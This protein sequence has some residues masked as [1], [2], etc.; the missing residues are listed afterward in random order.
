VID[1]HAL[2][3]PPDVDQA[4]ADWGANC[5]PC[6]LAAYMGVPVADVRDLFCD[7]ETR[8]YCNPTQMIAAI[9][10]AGM[11]ARTTAPRGMRAGRVLPD[12]GMAFLQFSGGWWDEKPIGVQYRKTHWIACH[13]LAGT[14][15][16]YDCNHPEAW[17][18]P[19]DWKA[20]LLPIFCERNR[21]KGAWVRSAYEI[22]Q[23]TEV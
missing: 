15:W 12:H 10:K 5:G 16:I 13:K 7:F 17:L 19:D 9:E 1:S 8:R 6:A 20:I 18:T 14:M 22:F 21:C 2:F 3:V 23:H 4:N 11:R